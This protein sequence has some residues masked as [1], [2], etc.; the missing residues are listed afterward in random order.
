[1]GIIVS[2]F[3][4]TSCLDNEDMD[5]VPKVAETNN[6]YYGKGGDSIPPED[7]DSIPPPAPPTGGEQG[8]NPIKP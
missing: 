1:M 8:Q 4:L 5:F 7:D 3:G 2:V 6:S